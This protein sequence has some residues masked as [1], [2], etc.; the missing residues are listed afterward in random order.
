MGEKERRSE[1][2]S[3][4]PPPP[5][6]MGPNN[7]P[8]SVM[9]GTSGSGVGGGASGGNGCMP[10]GSGAAGGESAAE[11]CG[12]AIRGS[13]SIMSSSSDGSSANNIHG[14]LLANAKRALLDQIEYEHSSDSSRNT[15]LDKLK[16]K[17]TL[18][19]GNVN[20]H[21]QSSSSSQQ[22]GSGGNNHMGSSGKCSLRSHALKKKT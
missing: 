6:L 2:T 18:L 13:L 7:M 20:G 3:L 11:K 5:H 9:C 16:S 19:N 12:A 4:P 1:L 21:G 22:N 17:Y 14:H 8:V 15:N 10:N